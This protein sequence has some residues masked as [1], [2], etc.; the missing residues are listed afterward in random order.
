MNDPIGEIPII[1]SGDFSDLNDSIQESQKIAEAGG[2]AIS[3]AFTRAASGG[4]ADLDEAIRLLTADGAEF[5]SG[6]SASAAGIG[7]ITAAAQQAIGPVAGLGDAANAAGSAAAAAVPPVKDLAGAAGSI[8]PATN[9]A[10]SGLKE[11]ADA[12]ISLEAALVVTQAL[13]EF[14]IE[15][16]TAYD[17]VQRATNSLTALTGGAEKA[18]EVLDAVRAIA[19]TQPFS[20]P[21]LAQSAQKLAAFGLSTQQIPQVLLDAANASRATGNSFDAIAAALARVDL[22][23]QISARQLVQLGISWGD[24]AKTAGVSIDEVQALL[25]KGGQSAADDMALLL[26]TVEQKFGAF[27]QV[28]LSIGEQWQVLQNKITTVFQGL[29]QAIIPVI[30]QIVDVLANSIVP[31]VKSAVDA[32]NGLPQPIKDTAVAFGLVAISVLP[33]AVAIG[34]FGLA[35]NSLTTIV[36]PVTGMLATLGVT[37]TTTATEVVAATATLGTTGL[38]GAAETATAAL[39]GAGLAGALGGVGLLLGTF[40]GAI[41]VTITDLNSLQQK[42]DAVVA[43]SNKGQIFDAINSGVTAARFK[44]AHISVDTLKTSVGGLNKE[45]DYSSQTVDAFGNIVLAAGQKAKTAAGGFDDFGIKVKIVADGLPG[46]SGAAQDVI[47]KQNKLEAEAHSA[48]AAYQELKSRMDGVT[49]TAADVARAYKDMTDAQAKVTAGAKDHALTVASIT[50]ALAKENESSTAAQSVLNTLQH[51]YDAAAAS[52]HGLTQATQLLGEAH[53]MLD[54]LIKKTADDATTWEGVEQGILTKQDAARASALNLGL[55]W[56]DLVAK[57]KA[58]IDVGGAADTALDLLFKALTAAGLSTDTFG[59]SMKALGLII[60]DQPPKID[61]MRGSLERLVTA[62][63]DSDSSARAAANS[64][65][66]LGSV[67]QSS[68]IGINAGAAALS[69]YTRLTDYSAQSAAQAGTAV[70]GYASLVSYGATAA[71]AAGE[72]VGKLTTATDSSTIASKAAADGIRL[73]GSGI[74]GAIPALKDVTDASKG[75]GDAIT[76]VGKS[77]SDAAATFPVLAGGWNLASAAVKE[78]KARYDELNNSLQ[79]GTALE[80]G[81]I[82]TVKQV[83][84]ALE[85]LKTAQDAARS[86][87]DASTVSVSKWTEAQLAALATAGLDDITIK[88]LTGDLSIYNTTLDTTRSKGVDAWNAITTAANLSDAAINKNIADLNKLNTAYTDSGAGILRPFGP[89]GGSG[90]NPAGGILRPFDPMGGSY[91]GGSF[92][93]GGAA[94]GSSGAILAPFSPLSPTSSIGG[95]FTPI[96]GIGGAGGNIGEGGGGYDFGLESLADAAGSVVSVLGHTAD[97]LSSDSGGLAY[98]ADVA[99]KALL[100]FAEKPIGLFYNPTTIVST[101][102]DPISSFGAL[103]TAAQATSTAVAALGAAVQTVA[104]SITGAVAQIQQAAFARTPI[105]PTATPLIPGLLSGPSFQNISNVGPTTGP[106]TVTVNASISNQQQA[107]N[108]INQL[109]NLGVRG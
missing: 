101:T 77:A 27:A 59:A 38:A 12:L 81:H 52:G 104:P 29:G 103:G 64:A 97:A 55:A 39:G 84:K 22:Q 49:V 11:M 67:S 42:W 21:E 94:G 72:S 60:P 65:G 2:Q 69:G 6:A 93:S 71:V 19:A 63:A 16:L 83:Q 31:A 30:N 91:T 107:N 28:P 109:R 33:L 40:G 108:L 99:K 66:N 56:Q 37:A 13:K 79:T 14:G 9:D 8:P 70:G 61:M 86:S 78:A 54:P 80:N 7:T 102:N 62:Q 76:I 89:S 3:S 26:K 85:D 24:L 44:D 92:G 105:T 41:A 74:N 53:K 75:A 34:G 23:G 90:G 20:F 18:D 36:G 15:A 51:A 45:I 95:G 68:S 87:L 46:L 50:A 58:G 35:L 100:Q 43:D 32:F 48:A 5:A 73:Y 88:S 57:Q 82:A 1:I 17:S 106:I 47:E 4:M 96:G 98:A 10:A 25:K